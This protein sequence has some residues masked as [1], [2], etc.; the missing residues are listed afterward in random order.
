MADNEQTENLEPRPEEIKVKKKRGKKLP[1]IL[2]IIL[3]VLALCTVGVMH[4]NTQLEKTFYQVKSTKVIDNIRVVCIADMHLKEFGEDNAD[5][6]Y[7]IEKLSPDIIA[8]AGDMNMES[9]PDNYDC[10]IS[11]CKKLNEIAPV[12][13]SLGNHEF[14]A[15]LFSDSD[16]YDDIKDAGISILNNETETITIGSTTIDIIGL[17]QGPSTYEEY[18]ASFFEKAMSADDNFKLVLTHYPENFL[19]V[20]EDYEIDLALSGHAHGG[21]VRLPWIGGLYAADQGFFP[22]LTEGYH[23][24]GNSKV[25]ITRG[26]WKSGK[27]PRINNKPEI[28]VVDIS[29]Y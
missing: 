11:L 3:A 10:V 29:W 4:Q 25:V 27:M 17:S 14:D 21:L 5:L 9:E 2:V 23:E 1:I 6:I 8:I 15:L 12:Y 20:I 22:E 26:L 16:I 24:I 18:G 13:Y 28:A 19:G 7:E